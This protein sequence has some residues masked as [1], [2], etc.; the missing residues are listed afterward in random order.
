M[1]RLASGWRGWSL[2][3]GSVAPLITT[4]QTFAMPRIAD[5]LDR[6]PLSVRRFRIRP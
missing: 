6:T 1:L 2:S 4:L 3:R 5:E